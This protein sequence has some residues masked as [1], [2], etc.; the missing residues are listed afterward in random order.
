MAHPPILI[1]VAGGK[2]GVGKSFLTANVAVALASRGHATIAVDLDLGNSNLHSFL[3]LENCHPGIGDFLHRTTDRPLADLVVPTSVPGLGFLPG[4]GRMPFMA[5]ITHHQKQALLRALPQLPARYIL[6][7]LSAGTSFNTLDFFLLSDRGLVVTTPEYPSVMKLLVFLKN[8][9]L[10][11]VAREFRGDPALAE[12]LQALHRQG[13][14][15]TTFTMDS[16]RCHL[17]RTDQSSAARVSDLCQR[18]RPRV[19]YNLVEGPEDLAILPDLDQSLAGVLSLACEHFGLVPLDPAV[20]RALKRPG[21][22]LARHPDCPP[23]ITIGRVADR[24]LRF[25]DQPIPGSAALLT[26]YAHTVFAPTHCDGPSRRGAG[27]GRRA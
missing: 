1:P 18:L 27:P 23:S 4:D 16:F 19:V 17:A 2:G 25:W 11:A 14:S 8:L 12:P 20:R 13:M 22:F 7:D 5:N 10:R 6:L 15:A 3:G 9:L 21:I 24:I 26:R